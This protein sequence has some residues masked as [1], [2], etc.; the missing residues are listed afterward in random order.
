MNDK[1]LSGNSYLRQV[2][3]LSKDPKKHMTFCTQS[4]SEQQLVLE[5][6]QLFVAVMKCGK[7]LTVV[8]QKQGSHVGTIG[9]SV[10]DSKEMSS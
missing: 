9:L 7:V 8:I 10:E 3:T 5:A 6:I 2:S 1:W 4:E